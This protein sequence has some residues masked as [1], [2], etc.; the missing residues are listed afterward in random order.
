MVFIWGAN[1]DLE[2]LVVPDRL[3]CLVRCDHASRRGGMMLGRP[4]S[5]FL[6]FYERRSGPHVNHVVHSGPDL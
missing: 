6:M 2:V 5:S 1:R 3:S 4:F